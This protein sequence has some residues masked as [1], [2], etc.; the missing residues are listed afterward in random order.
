MM[1]KLFILI[2][3]L[4][5]ACGFQP[6]YKVDKNFSNYKIQEVKFLG[7]RELSEEV[8]SKLPFIITKNNNLLNKLFIESKKNIFETSK[9][10]KGQVTS[11]RTVINLSFKIFNN[12]NNIID[13]KSI[14]KEFSYNV[15][16][17]KFKFKEYQNKVESNLINKLVEDI[18]LHLNI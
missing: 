11:Y 16:Q 9:D 2:L 8:Y 6:I 3:F 1:K 7:N 4:I 17:N 15:D 5:N 13:Q 14:K 12:S 18:I 10:S